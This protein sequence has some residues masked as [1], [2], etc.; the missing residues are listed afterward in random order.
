[1]QLQ[2]ARGGS[3]GDQGFEQHGAGGRIAA[4]LG[5]TRGGAWQGQGGPVYV[6][7]G[8]G[9]AKC[10]TAAATTATTYGRRIQQYG[11]QR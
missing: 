3:G 10:P 7:D 9:C 5:A 6:P 1:L 2:Q 11:A 4:N 8:R